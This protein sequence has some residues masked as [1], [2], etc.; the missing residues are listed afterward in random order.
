MVLEKLEVDGVGGVRLESMAAK[1]AE[2]MEMGS[3]RICGYCRCEGQCWGE[4][5]S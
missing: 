2:W 4:R 1:A 3:A 5:S